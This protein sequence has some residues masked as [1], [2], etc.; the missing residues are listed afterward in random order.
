MNTKGKENSLK[1]YLV[2]VA[3]VLGDHAGREVD[4][5]VGRVGRGEL[6][7][8]GFQRP[9]VRTGHLRRR[10]WR[11]LLEAPQPGLRLRHEGGVDVHP[12]ECEPPRER[13]DLREAWRRNGMEE[14]RQKKYLLL[15]KCAACKIIHSIQF[16]SLRRI[17]D[18][19]NKSTESKMQSTSLY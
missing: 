19:V 2:H 10:P 5:C 14:A 17:A 7:L 9:E 4:L 15:T 12:G 6:L 11:I 1:V 3:A 18:C 8:Q 13:L 16:R